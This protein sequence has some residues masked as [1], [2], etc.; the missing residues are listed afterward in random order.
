MRLVE[1]S[2]VR[3]GMVLARSI[4]GTRRDGAPLL[5]ARTSLTREL[6]GRLAAAGSSAVWIEDELGRGI[7]PSPEFP[8]DALAIAYCATERALAAATPAIAGKRT[9]DHHILRELSTAAGELAD[10]VLDYAPGAAPIADLAITAAGPAWHAVR[11]ALLGTFIGHRSLGQTG[12]VDQEGRQRFDGLDSRLQAL[13]LGL[14]THDLAV[15]PPAVQLRGPA[16]MPT[17][18]EQPRAHVRAAADLL[19]AESVSA[20][21]RVVVAQHHERFD[22]TGYPDGKRGPAIAQGARIAAIADCFDAL[23]APPDE[24]PAASLPAAVAAIE[25]GAGTRFDPALVRHFLALVPAYPVGHELH[26][27]DGRTGIVTRQRPGHPQHPY[28]R[29]EQRPGELV[30]VVADALA[31]RAA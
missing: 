8:P 3:D 4:P 22:G 11:V 27:G 23:I 18:D 15:P 1:L 14:L 6:A 30:E 31:P 29:V 20:S 28:V 5:R 21:A 17:E 7:E 12:W 13:A 2:A 9:L 24:R 19:P 26:L 10:A 16:R 25:S